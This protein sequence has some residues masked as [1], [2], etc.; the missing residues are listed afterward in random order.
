MAPPIETSDQPPVIVLGT[1]V[2]ALGVLRILGR[3]GIA[4]I[5]AER[6]DP[7]L[8][9]SRWFRPLP[10][11]V[12]PLGDQPLAEWLATSPLERA[13]LLP[14]SDHR[15]SEVAALPGALRERF[16]A[17]VPTTET[18]GRF[19]DKGGFAELLQTTG[20]AH[21]YSKP[22]GTPRDFDDAPED[23]FA[24]AML[25]PRDSQ[26]F[27]QQFHTK[28]LPVSSR[29]DA[30]VQLARVR[31]AK[32]DV[33]LQEYIPGPATAHFFVDGFVDRFHT[34]RA[35]FV[36]QRLRMYPLDF[37]NSTAMV[38]VRPETAAGAV[39]SVVSLLTGAGYRGVFSAEF[40]RD[41][42]DGVFK[43]LEVNTR[44][45]WFV[46]FAARCGVDV[47]RMAVDDALDRPVPTLTEYAIGKT[48]VHPYYDYW[49]CKALR[50]DGALTAAGWLRSW[51]GAMQPVF[52]W[53]DP[54]PGMLALAGTLGGFLR[55][56]L[57]RVTRTRRTPRESHAET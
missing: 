33:I 6:S 5:I 35:V 34:V 57:A 54:A 44:A 43:I 48:L 29:A 36:R 21:P 3:D 51:T 25:K 56:R 30:V 31:E 46:E 16:R 2:S 32:L 13:V 18:L 26:S 10:R 39:H 14:C 53:Q 41:P 8:R 42:R 50:R 19:V 27:I 45:W 9:R 7:L 22:I 17:S 12:V 55:S 4:T 37:G 24:N 40:K 20:V 52:E 38:S 23:V 49:A 47:C 1:G 15:V 28:A 11:G